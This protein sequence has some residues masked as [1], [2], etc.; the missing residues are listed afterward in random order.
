MNGKEMDWIPPNIQVT[1]DQHWA[2]PAFK[3]KSSIA[4]ENRAVDKEASTYCGGSISITSH[5]EK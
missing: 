1:L 5:F 2:S 4:K 3:N